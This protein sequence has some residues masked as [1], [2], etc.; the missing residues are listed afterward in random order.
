MALT[1]ITEKGI[2]DGEILNAD[3]NAS[4]AI[5][6]TKISSDFGGQDVTTT[7]DV[8]GAN[9][10]LSHTTPTIQLNDS[11]NNPDFVLQ[12]NNGVFRIRDNTNSADR[13]NI[14]SSGN[15]GIGTTS[16]SSNLHV[17]GSGEILRLE[18]TATTG[19]NYINFN[20]ADE[21]KAFV[22]MA[23]ASDDSFSVWLAKSSNLRFATANT[24]RMRIDSSGKVGIGTNSPT[25]IL[26]IKE[27]TNKNL[28]FTGGIGQIGNVTGFY[29]VNDANNA[30]VDIGMT[31]STVRFG[32][33]AGERGRFTGDGLCFNGDTA[34][35]N[36]LN[37]YEEGTFTP[38]WD[39]GGGVTFS[40]SQQHGWYTKIGNTVTFTLYL[41]GYASTI[42]SGN[43][44]N[45]VALQ[46]L[47]FAIQNN[48]R[49]Y[50]AFTIGRTYK[51]D[52][53]SDQRIYS[54]GSYGSTNARF[55]METDDSTG[56]I[57]V[58]DQLNQNTCELFLSGTY[59]I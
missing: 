55:I 51:F 27:G 1:Q 53:N 42:T 36:A 30:I 8:N 31:G 56:N 20:D 19:S 34:A 28:H 38:N 40:Y 12:N 48:N 24:E 14:D 2:K 15:V 32:T 59:R 11:N 46:G 58:A 10:V 45:G 25:E 26:H 43:G 35:A 13:I 5:A 16:P 44:S 33:T 47:P 54:Y 22:G 4:A 37:D 57:M 3:I 29:A 6:G 49:Y 9:L 17:K 52:I 50:P 18:T 7:G 23:S 41:Q 21:N 39:A